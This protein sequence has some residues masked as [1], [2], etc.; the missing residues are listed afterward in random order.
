LD[1]RNV[2]GE[3]NV[4][5]P[6][7][8]IQHEST[9]VGRFHTAVWIGKNIDESSGRTNKQMAPFPLDFLETFPLPRTPHG[10]LDNESSIANNFLGFCGNLFRQFAS[11]RNNDS[12]NIPGNG[13]G[14]TP[15]ARFQSRIF[16]HL[17]KH[18]NQERQRFSCA[19]FSLSKP[20][21]IQKGETV[22]LQFKRE[23][24]W[25]GIK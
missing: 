17:L 2:G 12:T 16:Q 25:Q 5:K 7:S 9:Q 3:P 8:F 15:V 20:K 1:P 4:E 22:S 11:R 14:H 23:I 18:G 10:S 6:I 21:A 19:S 24:L 13:P